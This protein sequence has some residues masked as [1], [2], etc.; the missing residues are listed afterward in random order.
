MKQMKLNPAALGKFLRQ[1]EAAIVD[2]FEG[3]LLD[4]YLFDTKRGIM[5]I[6]ET[7]VNEWTS[8]YTVLFATEPGERI[9]LS[10]D[11]YERMETALSY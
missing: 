3:S 5:A 8:T 7:F 11:F 6:Y 10:D 2:M 9:E 4:N 1:N